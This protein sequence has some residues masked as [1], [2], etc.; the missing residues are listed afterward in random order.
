MKERL[1]SLAGRVTVNCQQ[2]AFK[3]CTVCVVE[4]KLESYLTFF[5]CCFFELKYMLHL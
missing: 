5:V 1:M 4:S 3:S 2:K